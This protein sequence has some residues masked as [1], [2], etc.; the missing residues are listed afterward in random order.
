MGWGKAA[1]RIAQE[2]LS[3]V[4]LDI[5]FLRMPSE[6]REAKEKCIQ[7][8]DAVANPELFWLSHVYLAWL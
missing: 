3:Q 2:G 8:L 4:V 6:H 1:G 7:A 5:Q